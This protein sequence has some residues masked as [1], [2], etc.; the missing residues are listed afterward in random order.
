M[1]RT[2]YSTPPV[3]PAMVCVMPVTVASETSAAVSQL[4]AASFHCTL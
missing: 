4:S 3:S 1:T 2:A